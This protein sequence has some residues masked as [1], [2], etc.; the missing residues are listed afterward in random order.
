M[1]IG[2]ETITIDI[3]T[4]FKIYFKSTDVIGASKKVVWI[5]F[6]IHLLHN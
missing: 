5:K 6:N 4:S 2:K 1:V 3:K